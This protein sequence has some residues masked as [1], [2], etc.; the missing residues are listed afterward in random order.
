MPGSGPPGLEWFCV[1]T[2]P[3]HEHIA[4]A[5]LRQDTG[6]EV[7][8]P[9]IRFRRPTRCGPAWVSEAL[10]PNYVFARFDLAACWRR[11]Q[12]ARAVRG[13][14]HF[15]NRWPTIPCSTIEDLRSAMGPDEIRVVPSDFRPGEEVEILKGALA[16]L[17]AV[18]TRVIP[19]RQRVAILMD[20]LGRQTSVDL[21]ADQ[22]VPR[23]GFRQHAVLEIS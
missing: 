15:G 7:F 21:P 13:V 18:V 1:Q 11:V 4:A 2:H 10:F 8:L 12:S 5:Q 6:I 20:F 22:L 23:G 3:K 9:R 19:N 17:Q 14:V 16:G